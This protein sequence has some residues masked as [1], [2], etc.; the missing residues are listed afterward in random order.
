MDPS[1]ELGGKKRKGGTERARDQKKAAL[2][3]DAT[4]YLKISDMFAAR[5]HGASTSA[6]AASASSGGEDAQQQADKAAMTVSET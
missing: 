3:A 5:G 1:K 4:K 2:Q 6:A